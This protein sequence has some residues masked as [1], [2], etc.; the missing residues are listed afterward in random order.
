MSSKAASFSIASIL[1][2]IA[3]ISS[4][5]V[6]AFFGL[7]LAAIAFICGI[8]G[9]LLALSSDVRGGGISILAVILSFV[10][11]LAAIVKT[12]IWLFS[13]GG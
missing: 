6:G 12:I 7:V 10:G 1:A 11:V 2:L 4:F 5:F 3:S 9:I 8:F 13:L